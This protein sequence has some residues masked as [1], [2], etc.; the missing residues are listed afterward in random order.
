MKTIFLTIIATSGLFVGHVEGY[1]QSILTS[2][3]TTSQNEREILIQRCY[4][5]QARVAA[6][7]AGMGAGGSGLSGSGYRNEVKFQI[8]NYLQAVR[9][10]TALQLLKEFQAN[11]FRDFV[12]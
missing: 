8:T 10:H 11:N 1:Q 9:T 6:Q 5:I 2:Y 4:E 3:R 7:F 12:R